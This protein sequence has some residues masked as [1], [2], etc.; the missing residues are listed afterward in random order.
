MIKDEAFGGGHRWY[1]DKCDIYHNGHINTI[2]WTNSTPPT[3]CTR[4]ETPKVRNLKAMEYAGKVYWRLYEIYG[5]KFRTP[6]TTRVIADLIREN[7][8][9][10]R[11]NPH[12]LAAIMN[13]SAKGV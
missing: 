10:G 3:Y 13:Q 4:C 9:Q 1:C 12:L 5:D 8:L 11:Y 7:A 2:S 6:G